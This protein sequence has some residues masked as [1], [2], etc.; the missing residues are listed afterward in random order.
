MA[1]DKTNGAGAAPG[2][3][4]E[5]DSRQPGVQARVIAQ[6]VKDLSFEN[7]NIERML[8]GPGDNPNLNLEIN[9]NARRTG[10]QT[11]ESAIDLRAHATNAAGTIYELEV[12]YG[13]MFHIE[14]LPPQ[15]LEPFLLIN[16][17]AL[18]FPFLRRL[19]ADVT[20]E[21]GFPPLYVD[22]ID[23]GALYLNRQRTAGAPPQA[24]NETAGN[25]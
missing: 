21:G 4:A 15:S 8:A 22:P 5:G 25:A 2:A 14:N 12:I 3:S 17:P 11:F 23:F 6:Y 9:V 16:C 1:E 19:V 13:G 18:I 10:D 24:T 7:P 20:R